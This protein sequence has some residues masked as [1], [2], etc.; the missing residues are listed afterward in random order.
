VTTFHLLL[1]AHL[2]LA[3]FA[4]GPLVHAATTAG[5][6]VRTGDGK[7]T[8]SASRV[9]RIY[10]YASVL[11][12]LVG[13]PLMSQKPYGGQKLGEFGDTYIWLSIVLWAVAIALVLGVAVPTLDRATKSIQAQ[14]SVVALT[15]RVAAAGGIV[16]LL[17]AAIIVLMTFRPG[18]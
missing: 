1:A 12:L 8:A 11:I 17:F 16:G 6:G 14:E 4:V 15:G 5:R 3:V 7:A 9:L 13:F 10:S 18:Q 2:I